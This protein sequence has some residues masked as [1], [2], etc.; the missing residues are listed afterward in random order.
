MPMAIQAYGNATATQVV[1]T[2]THFVIS[3]QSSEFKNKCRRLSR[4]TAI[5]R[6]TPIMARI[7]DPCGL[8]GIIKAITQCCLIP[9]AIHNIKSPPHAISIMAM[10]Y[11]LNWSFVHDSDS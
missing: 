8:R 4:F 7:S 2:A 5:S 11:L 10:G 1:A 6:P 3:Y 9:S